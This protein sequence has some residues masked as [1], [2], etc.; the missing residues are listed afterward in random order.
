MLNNYLNP[1]GVSADD[2]EAYM[3]KRME[4]PEYDHKMQV[5]EFGGMRKTLIL[6][7]A[8][9]LC[10]E[11][12]YKITVNERNRSIEIDGKIYH[13]NSG[14]W[15]AKGKS[16]WYRSANTQSFLEKYVRDSAKI[17]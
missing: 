17:N 10:E 14:K 12:G 8:A 13:P 2:W 4:T 15:R 7:R 1:K 5:D 9:E 3:E 16:K 11:R 6:K